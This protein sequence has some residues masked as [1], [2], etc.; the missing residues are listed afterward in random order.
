VEG[1]EIVRDRML[2]QLAAGQDRLV[3]EPEWEWED[4]DHAVEPGR[5]LRAHHRQR[6][7]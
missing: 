7:A 5:R 3:A 1:A 4:A 6:P 2:R